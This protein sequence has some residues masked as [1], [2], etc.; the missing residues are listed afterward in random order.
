MFWV[1]CFRFSPYPVFLDW[2]LKNYIIFTA[3][4]AGIDVFSISH[5]VRVVH[6]CIAHFGSLATWRIGF[7]PPEKLVYHFFKIHSY[8]ISVMVK[9]DVTL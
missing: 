8:R 9:K 7:E 1:L 2:V 4:F 6:I 3:F 5:A